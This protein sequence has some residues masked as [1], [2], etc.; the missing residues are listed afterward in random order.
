VALALLAGTF[1]VYA[2]ALGADFAFIDDFLYVTRNP[3]VIP[4]LTWKGLAWACTS[5]RESNWHPLTWLSLMLDAE[6]YG[7]EARGYHVTNVL[8]HA[9]NVLLVFLF[10]HKATGAFWRSA[11]VAG[12]FAAHPQHVE[13]VAWISER[14]DVLSIFFGLLTLLAWL[15]Y[16]RQGGRWAYALA[17]VAF[18]LS[19]TA[20]QT[21]VTLPFLLLLLDVWP[22][23]RT[24]EGAPAVLGIPLPGRRLLLEKV[25]FLLLAVGTGLLTLLAQEHSMSGL[26]ALPLG[27]RLEN[28]VVAVARYVLMTFWPVGLAPFYPHPY[29]HHPLAVFVASAAF[30]VAASALCIALARRWPFLLVG[31]LWFLLALLPVAGIVQ[32]GMQSMADRYMYWPHIG[33]FA[34]LVW[35]GHALARGRPILCRV[36]TA[37]AVAVLLVLGTLCFRQAALWS[38]NR[39]LLEHTAEVTERNYMVHNSLALLD[40]SEKDF[41]SYMR[42]YTLAVE[43]NK[44]YVANK[45]F[46]QAYSFAHWGAVDMGILESVLALEL[47]PRHPSALHNL[48]VLLAAKGRLADAILVLERAAEMAPQLK[49]ITGTLEQMRAERKA[50]LE[51]LRSAQGAL[52]QPAGSEESKT[53]A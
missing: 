9:G 43:Y 34:G 37:V 29:Q 42:H 46:L 1:L 8:L 6:L 30:F 33:L 4:G 53:G 15:R 10:L 38:D 11:L 27:L 47:Q 39:K 16:A 21:L 36:Q 51:R 31:W 32:V 7:L 19:L 13:S 35:S 28:A 48:A 41:D 40:F 12:L 3:D 24:A 25:P 49:F 44:H 52:A 45:H 23:E 2:R 50:E 26:A 17:L 18:G 22:L 14:K 20:K 5:F